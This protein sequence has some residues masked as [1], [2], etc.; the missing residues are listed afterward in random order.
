MPSLLPSLEEQDP[1]SHESEAIRLEEIK[2]KALWG[3]RIRWVS[4]GCL[5]TPILIRTPDRCGTES[6]HVQQTGTWSIDHPFCETQ[7]CYYIGKGRISGRR[8]HS[9]AI[10][11][12]A[13][14]LVLTKLSRCVENDRGPGD[15][16]SRCL[17]IL[18]SNESKPIKMNRL[19][20][21]ANLRGEHS[22]VQQAQPGSS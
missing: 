17:Y 4:E 10:V 1:R 3:E 22:L 8:R 13:I 19:I 6:A 18:T 5:Y 7:T 2:S 11:N 21:W 14:G 12:N 15:E 9:R 16:E 20:F